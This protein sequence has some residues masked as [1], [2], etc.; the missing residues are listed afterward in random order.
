M[1]S[2]CVAASARPRL[3]RRGDEVPVADTKGVSSFD[4]SATTGG[5]SYRCTRGCGAD[6]GS[7][8]G[9]DDHNAQSH[10]P[11]YR[12]SD[13]GER[14]SSISSGE[15]ALRE[16]DSWQREADADVRSIPSLGK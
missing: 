5:N 12:S 13:N 2:L 1:S 4:A 10:S 15:A 16:S 7:P 11:D 9:Q 14:V 3:T 8:E 6:V